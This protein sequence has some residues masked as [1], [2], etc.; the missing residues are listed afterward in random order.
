MRAAIPVLTLAML[1]ALGACHRTAPTPSADVATI[2]VT[3]GPQLGAGLWSQ[4]VSD[5]HGVKTL[6]YCL[7]AASSGALAAFNRQLDGRCSRRDMAMATG[8]IWRFATSC[9]MGAGGKVATQGV[10]RGDFR[11]HY[12]IEAESQT[13]GAADRGADGPNRMLADIQRLGDCPRDM[14]AGDV[15]LT[16][17]SR[18]RLERLAAPA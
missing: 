12:F 6:R 2:S 13:V 5:R 7:D 17:G 11:T 16:D 4:S 1:A 8:G 9:D 10:I 15:V 3:G 14:K 18:S